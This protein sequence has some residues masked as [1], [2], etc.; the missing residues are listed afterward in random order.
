M[1]SILKDSDE[2][3]DNLS[4]MSAELIRATRDAK[5]LRGQLVGISGIVE[6]KNYE[7]LS[8]FLSGTGAWKI[9]NKFKATTQT[10]SQLISIGERRISNEAITLQ[11]I[12][13]LEQRRA[14]FA[15]LAALAAK[16]ENN[17]KAA[18]LKLMEQIPEVRGLA[19]VIGTPAAIKRYSKFIKDANNNVKDTLKSITG[20]APSN[21]FQKAVSKVGDFQA[22]ILRETAKLDPNYKQFGS[23]S[24]RELNPDYDKRTKRR[25]AIMEGGRFVKNRGTPMQILKELQK[26]SKTGLVKFVSKITDKV[27][28]VFSPSRYKERQKKFAG[29]ADKVSN[30]TS[31]FGK[32]FIG[33]SVFV[34]AFFLLYRIL[35]NG[36]FIQNIIATISVF[37]QMLF[38][39][40]SL[41]WEGI[42]S[43]V[44]GFKTGDFYKVIGG[45]VKIAFGLIA[46]VVTVATT[47][48]IGA[49]MLVYSIIKGTVVAILQRMTSSASKFVSTL[50]YIGAGI[51]FLV[52]FFGGGWIPVLVGAVLTG[53]GMLIE[54]IGFASGGTV[55]RTGPALVGEKGPEFV[56]LPA[57]ARVFSNRDSSKM[58]PS[59]GTTNNIT[60]QV[61]GRVGASDQEIKDIARKVSR[62]IG[63]QMNRT[64]STAVR[65]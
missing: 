37:G 13:D 19:S 27:S 52:A 21:V 16:A 62:E 57:G 47:L 54:K 45:L 33:F 20:K 61:S 9:L 30:I 22:S 40:L 3:L 58:V 15:G 43:I 49:I 41:V 48:L 6:N 8:R 55:P 11:G 26:Q 35:K 1:S 29:V 51:A 34:I 60:V 64:G 63:L 46:I 56:K 39:S 10:L 38:S 12:A 32:F 50:L 42:S 5:K 24:F 23:D 28:F 53:I 2:L 25:G 31:L 18:T 59:S 7:I 44:D 4:G 14:K 36:D 65:F 17:D